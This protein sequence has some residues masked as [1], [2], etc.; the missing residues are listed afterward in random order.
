LLRVAYGRTELGESPAWDPATDYI[1]WVDINGRKLLRSRLGWDR[2]ETWQ[3]PELAGF[4]VL[5]AKGRPAI[6]M[7]SGI[8]SFNADTAAFERIVVFDGPGQ[9]FN[10]AT[11]DA[12]GRLW[13]STMTLD[14]TKGTGKIHRVTD[15]LKLHTIVEGLAIP[16]GMAA[17]LE[18]GRFYYSDSH[19]QVQNIWVRKIPEEASEPGSAALFATT[20][21]LK[22]RP[23]GAA[24]DEQG[25]YWIAGV[26]GGELYVFDGQGRLDTVLPVPFPAPT[27]CA[28]TGNEGRM[29]ALTSKSIGAD[30]GY[31][32]LADL[33]ESFSPGIVQP[34]W[35]H[36]A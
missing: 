7:Q 6:G 18:R 21:E 27:K 29:I 5:M 11:V 33:P 34:Y 4:V 35:K 16:N 20:H 25:R 1:W 28:F 3:T 19:P 30:G 36:D 24:L 13:A 8:F 32:A 14:A 2:V 26:D 15:D 10:D 12:Q 31:L 22:G 17:D 23:D 9:R